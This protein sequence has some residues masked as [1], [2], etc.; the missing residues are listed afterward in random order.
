MTNA[1]MSIKKIITIIVISII[2]GFIIV[3]FSN[4]SSPLVRQNVTGSNIPNPPSPST[5]PTPP[6]IDTNSNLEEEI[7]KLEPKDY[8]EEFSN[9]RTETSNPQR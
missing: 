9:L 1:K 3:K 5:E 2:A 8:S 4:N 7:D 6:P